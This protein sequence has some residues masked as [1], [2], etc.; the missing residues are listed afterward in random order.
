MFEYF[1][2][3]QP[4]GLDI[5]NSSI[6]MIQLA[7]TADRI[8]V[9]DAQQRFIPAEIRE[10]S[11]AKSE[12]IAKA[13]SEMY[14]CGRFKGK[15]VITAIPNGMLT[16]KTL[17]TSYDEGED[18]SRFLM[19]QASQ[20]FSIDIENSEINHMMVV[21][22]NLKDDKKNEV[23]LFAVPRKTIVERLDLLDEVGLCP[24]SIDAL[25][26]A[27]FRSTLS[28]FR[29]QDDYT[30]V[31]VLVDVGSVYTTITIGKGYNIAFVKI[32]PIGGKRFNQIV[33]S[34]LDISEQQAAILRKKI[35][36]EDY[37]DQSGDAAGQAVYDAMVLAISELA[38]EISLCFRYFTVT[39]RG[40]IPKSLILSGGEA[41][42]KVL[43]DALR[44]RLN[45]DIELAQPLS[46][47]DLSAVDVSQL[48]G[49]TLSEWSVATGLALKGIPLFSAGKGCYAR[50]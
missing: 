48:R 4:I 29:R 36:P 35:N 16:V 13:I 25:P 32:I 7:K 38:R 5:G 11:Q 30:S 22:L 24:V 28:K 3:P 9:L 12:F 10:D 26:C 39:F 31:H 18:L 49:Y 15:D 27:M 45:V 20:K 2:K 43:V 33:A 50:N 21:N 19:E 14:A 47:Y 41:Y 40:Q 37:S 1:K 23:I 8:K 44:Q 6:R 42:E 17:R 34:R 46:G